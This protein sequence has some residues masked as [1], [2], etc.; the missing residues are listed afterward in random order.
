L[1]PGIKSATAETALEIKMID[2]TL[3]SQLAS[4]QL[5]AI[6]IS[7]GG[8]CFPQGPVFKVFNGRIPARFIFLTFLGKPPIW[9]PVNKY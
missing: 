3:Q 5:V 9:A 2:K 1:P 6:D 4:P 7:S 8:L